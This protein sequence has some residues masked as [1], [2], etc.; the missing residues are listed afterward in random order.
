MKEAPPD[1]VRCP[2]CES[3]DVKREETEDRWFR[4]S[5]RYQC[6]ACGRVFRRAA[7]EKADAKAAADAA[8][9]HPSAKR[10]VCDELMNP[11]GTRHHGRVKRWKCPAC[12]RTAE[13]TGTAV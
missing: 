5:V 9:A 6:R 4:K 8:W 1:L 3:N 12:D 2:T 10:C 13:T 11:Y 7:K